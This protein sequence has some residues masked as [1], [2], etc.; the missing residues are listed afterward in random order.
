MFLLDEPGCGFGR[1]RSSVCPELCLG[2]A[3][4]GSKFGFGERALVQLSSQFD[5]SNLRGFEVFFIRI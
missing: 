5:L 4:V 2:M 3:Q 1:V